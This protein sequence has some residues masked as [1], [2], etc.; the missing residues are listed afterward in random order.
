MISAMP[1]I[2]GMFFKPVTWQIIGWTFHMV[3]ASL[4]QFGRYGFSAFVAYLVQ[5]GWVNGPFDPLGDF[6]LTITAAIA[7]VMKVL[8]TG[9]LWGLILA[10]PTPPD[11]SWRI[12]SRV[13]A[14]P[15]RGARLGRPRSRDP[16]PRDQDRYPAAALPRQPC[17]L[18]CG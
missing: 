15:G 17:D 18:A 13:R 10:L 9:S 12:A 5:F 16:R 7:A 3:W 2:I 14:L 8:S 1:G 11:W 4:Y 6:Y